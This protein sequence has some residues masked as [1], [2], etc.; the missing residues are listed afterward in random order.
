MQE[1]VEDSGGENFISGEQLRP[2]ATDLLVVMRI[3]PRP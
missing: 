1:P 2:V 3:E